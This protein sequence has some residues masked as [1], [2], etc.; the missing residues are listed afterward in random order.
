MLIV[1]V[2]AVFL[3]DLTEIPEAALHIIVVGL[4]LEN[5]CRWLVL[6]FSFNLWAVKG[7]NYMIY[8]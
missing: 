1:K 4:A 3:Q 8:L 6:C 5:Y 2:E 7:R